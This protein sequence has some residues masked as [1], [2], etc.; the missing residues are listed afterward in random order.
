MSTELHDLLQAVLRD[1]TKLDALQPEQAL[2]LVSSLRE[3]LGLDRPVVAASVSEI[4]ENGD[5]LTVVEAAALLRVTRRWL[6]RH[7]KKLPFTR[8]LSRKALRFSRDGLERWVAT[9]RT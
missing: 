6:Y 5:L 4:P 9:R 7:A 8:R 2:S 3:V 1:R